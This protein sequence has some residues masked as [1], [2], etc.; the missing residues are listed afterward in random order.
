[1][2]GLRRMAVGD[3]V[4][5]RGR[6]DRVIGEL[7]LGQKAYQLLERLGGGGRERYRVYDRLAGPRGDYRAIHVLPRSPEVEQQL[8]VLHRLADL[9]NGNVP[10]LV[11]YHPVRDKAAV[12]GLEELALLLETRP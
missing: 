8:G 7:T 1:M 3:T 5:F 4:R 10:F 6:V 11:E 12:E 9:R 2:T